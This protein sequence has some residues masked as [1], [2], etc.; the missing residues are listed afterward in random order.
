[1]SRWVKI[2]PHAVLTII[3][4]SC[5]LWMVLRDQ[6]QRDEQ[7]LRLEQS[8]QTMDL[9]RDLGFRHLFGVSGV[10]AR[11]RLP[12][13]ENHY[14]LTLVEYVDG[15]RTVLARTIK[16]MY[17]D[18]M[19]DTS[20]TWGKTNDGEKL[21]FLHGGYIK[22]TGDFSS[23]YTGGSSIFSHKEDAI[24]SLPVL[25]GEIV[26]NEIISR[27][28]RD[29]V[30]DQ[31]DNYGFPQKQIDNRKHVMFLMLRSFPSQS[32]ALAWLSSPSQ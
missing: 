9:D 12:E 27:E 11:V 22:L 28:L 29:G 25:D 32:A 13:G 21:L 20:V 3:S 17:G 8:Q 5:C 24:K 7:K 26:L 4:V 16:T 14:G 30:T 10:V 2:L 19:L 23:K 31:N 1:M 18:R 15:M 6:R